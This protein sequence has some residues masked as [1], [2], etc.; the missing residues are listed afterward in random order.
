MAGIGQGLAGG[1]E[2]DLFAQLLEQRLAHGFRQLLDLQR[3]RGRRQVQRFGGARE[4]AVAR[5]RVKDAQLV[6]GGVAQ[7]HGVP[8]RLIDK[9]LP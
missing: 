2:K 4:A 7:L 3:Q 6:Q 9:N 1:G 5:H 8:F